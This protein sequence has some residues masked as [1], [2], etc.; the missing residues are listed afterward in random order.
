M[1]CLDGVCFWVLGFSIIARTEFSFPLTRE[2]LAAI[3]AYRSKYTDYTVAGTAWN[4]NNIAATLRATKF[5][6]VAHL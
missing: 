4:A 3:T 1:L 6:G 5:C 2:I